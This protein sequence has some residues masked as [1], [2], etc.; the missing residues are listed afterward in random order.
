MNDIFKVIDIRYLAITIVTLIV[1]VA[2]V[3]LD[4]IAQDIKYHQFVDQR[5]FLKIPN[6]WN[7]I[8]NLPFLLVGVIGLYSIFHSQRINLINEMKAAYIVFFLGVLLVALGSGFY[9]L[10]PENETLVWDR[11]PMTFA[12]M[13]LFSIIIGE[14]ISVRWGKWSLWPLLVLGVFSIFYWHFTEGKGEGDLRLY[15]LVQFLPLLLIPLILVLFTPGFTHTRGYWLLLCAYVF[16]KI[17][18]YFD[19]VVLNNLI[20]L[21]GHSIKHL[22]AALGIYFL[23]NAYNNRTNLNSHT[24]E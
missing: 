17:F 7:V 8:S 3:M 11:L 21:S 13:A 22:V 9:H 5:T 20:I 14:F 10:S 19:G 6:F 1:I 18:E 23:L 4:P 12:F 24:Q 16:A 15:I 2:V